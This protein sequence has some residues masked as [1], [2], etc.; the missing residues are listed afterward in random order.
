MYFLKRKIPFSIIFYSVMVFAASYSIVDSLSPR[1]SRRPLLRSV[2]YII[3]HTTEGG[4]EGSFQ[5]LHKDGK[6]HYMVDPKGKV[7]R[8]MD[9]NRL[10]THAGRSLWDGRPR[11]DEVSLGIEVVGFHNKMPSKDQIR[12]LGELLSELKTR[13]RISDDRVLTH[14]QVAYGVPNKWQANNHRGRKRCAMLMATREL[15]RQIG[16][17]SEPRHD[18]DVLSGKLAIGDPYLNK[19]IYDNANDRFVSTPYRRALAQVSPKQVITKMYTGDQTNIISPSRSAWFIAREQYDSPN[20]IYL[21][22][23]GKKQIRGDKIKDWSSL[24]NGTKII[25]ASAPQNTAPEFEISTPPARM[26]K[27]VTED[28]TPA[29]AIARG[30]AKSENTFYLIPG[31]EVASG[32]DLALNEESLLWSLPK[33]TKILIGYKKGESISKDRTAYRISKESDRPWNSPLTIYRF[34][35]G[36]VKTGDEIDPSLIQANTLI[37]LEN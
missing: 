26:F 19:V 20:T 22:P 1:N 21:F 2:Q 17:N 31:R 37:F 18:P 4:T 10:A 32:K 25:L 33:G 14:S 34:P 30:E 13:Y 24:P 27:E 35:D 15:R 3:L 29:I 7:Y 5:T 9:E 12:T 6:I 16:L 28:T 23:D 8:I 36:T 11:M